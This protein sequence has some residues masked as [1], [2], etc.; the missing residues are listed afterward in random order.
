MGPSPGHLAARNNKNIVNYSALDQKMQNPPR[1][2]VPELPG[3]KTNVIYRV[4]GSG[5]PLSRKP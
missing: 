3:A 5:P 2:V 1:R 4:L